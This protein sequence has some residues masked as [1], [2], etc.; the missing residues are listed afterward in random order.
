MSWVSRREVL[1]SAAVVG[2]WMLFGE[3]A[4]LGQETKPAPAA[5]GVEEGPYHLP[6]LP[7]GYAD[8]EPFLSVQTLKLHHDIH[9]AG[10][11][12]GANAAVAELAAIRQAGGAEIKRVRAVTDD[13]AFNRSGHL[14]HDLYWKSMK[15]GGGGEPPAGSEAAKLIKRDFGALEAFHAHLSAAAAQVHGSGWG[16]LAYEPA[17]QRLLVLA[18]EKHEN[19]GVWGVVPLLALDVW[20]H[21]YYL[22]YQNKRAD[23]IKA[24]AEV[25]NWATVEERLQ[26]ALKLA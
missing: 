11:V 15:K 21:A 22:Q 18:A 14:L 17:A 8:L 23:Y 26:M 19:M 9:H 7:Y 20:E 2:G 5:G 10:Y 3:H 12:K 4:A 6:P 16:I 25:I 1:G 24:F 13:L